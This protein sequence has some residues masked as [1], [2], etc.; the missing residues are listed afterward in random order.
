MNLS[1]LDLM[2]SPNQEYPVKVLSLISSDSHTVQL[3][4]FYWLICILGRVTDRQL[5]NVWQGYQ[6][7]GQ[8]VQLKKENSPNRIV[9]TFH[10]PVH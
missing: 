8:A 6:L 7:Q 4:S 1:L 2:S 9:I 5:S 3:E 10:S